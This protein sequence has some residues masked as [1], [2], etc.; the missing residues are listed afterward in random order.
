[1]P[2]PADPSQSWM[3]AFAF[4]ASVFLSLLRIFELL[5]KFLRRPQLD[6][7]VT[8]E[9]FFRLTDFGETLFCNS[10]QLS[11]NGPLVISDTRAVLE[12]IDS[13]VKSFPFRILEFG[14]K[15]KGE[16]AVPSFYFHSRSAVTHIAEAKPERVLYACVHEAYEDHS[17]NAIAE[18]RREVL[19]YKQQLI[20][21]AVSVTP[22]E[23]SELQQQALRRVDELVDRNLAKVMQFVQ[24]EQGKY[25][26]T[27]EVDYLNPKFWFWKKPKTKKSSIEFSIDADIRNIYL[28]GLRQSL[29]VNA[30]NLILDRQTTVVLPEYQPRRIRTIL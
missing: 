26:F 23:T 20:N 22:D 7:R 10:I 1:M 2:T 24:L 5:A 29:L 17:Q 14:E 30:T 21:E 27:L 9:A 28:V 13:P 25:K 15:V 18:F 12:K 4:W 16:G 8:P 3:L 6:L 11:W 19:E